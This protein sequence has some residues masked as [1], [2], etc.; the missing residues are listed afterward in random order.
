MI[1]PIVRNIWEMIVEFYKPLIQIGEF[2]V[3]PEVGEDLRPCQPGDW[4]TVITYFMPMI[5]IN[6]PRKSGLNQKQKKQK[7]KI[8][9]KKI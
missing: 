6:F 4:K 9:S 2:T 7:A 8:K 3:E 1:T 5:I